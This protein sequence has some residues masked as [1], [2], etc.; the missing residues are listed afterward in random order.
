[1]NFYETSAYSG[2]NIEDAIKKITSIASEMDTVPYFSPEIADRI[3]IDDADDIPPPTSSSC[4][5]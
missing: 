1:M 3:N 2:S 4:S 5:C